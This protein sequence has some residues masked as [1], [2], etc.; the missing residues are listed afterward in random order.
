M[1]RKDFQDIL[2]SIKIPEGT[3]TEDLQRLLL[4]IY[5]ALMQMTPKRLFKYRYCCE[6]HISAFEKDEMWMSTSDLFNDPFDTLIRYD[7]EELRKVCDTITNPQVFTAMTRYFAEN[8]LMNPIIDKLMDEKEM[9]RLREL[10]KHAVEN[11]VIQAPSAEQLNDL[12]LSLEIFMSMLPKVAQRF[13]TV[14][15]LSERIDSVL[16]WSHYCHYHTGFALGY[17]PMLFLLPNENGLG[18]FPV[19]YSNKRYDANEF[20]MWIFCSV[21]KISM[22]N[23]DK[24]NSIKLLL[25][26]SLEWE[27]EQE[28]RL[29]TSKTG[30][31]FNGRAESVN[32]KPNSIYYGCKISDEN[33]KRLHDIAVK[34]GLEE[35]FMEVNY[36]SDEYRMIVK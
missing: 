33:H 19:V 30:D 11:E 13:S 16:M 36:A 17:D 6:N 4:P 12:R 3:S 21:F 8:G 2:E 18:I 1:N 23:P 25:Y 34:K 20:L 22:H 9:L 15:C 35:H 5:T 27:Y 26:K 29:V 28:W 14:G 31:L 24:M 7:A 32:V 10:A